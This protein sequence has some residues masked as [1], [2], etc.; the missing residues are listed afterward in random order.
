VPG[1]QP[2]GTIHGAAERIVKY[3][4]RPDRLAASGC[5]EFRPIA[6]NDA[7]AGRA[8]NRRVDIVI[9]RRHGKS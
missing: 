5:A 2:R 6:S 8:H 3:G 7:A 9:P 4:L 1:R